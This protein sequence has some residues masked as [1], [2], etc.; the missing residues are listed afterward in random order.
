MTSA[1]SAY[2]TLLK[3]GDAA[4][5][6]VFTTIAEVVNIGGPSLSLDPIDVTNHSSPS[7]WKEFVAGLKDGGEVSFE[8]NFIPTEATHKNA[9]G[10]LLNDLD[11]RT[12]R[13]FE[14]IFPDSGATKWTFAAFITGFEV[15]APVDGKLSA[16]I[17]LKLSGV[18]VIA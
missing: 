12:L 16:S 17:T 3:I 14:L 11:G 7:A 5:P 1:L 4:D 18:P 2:A 15:A 9:A 10:G 6:E 13:N 8:V